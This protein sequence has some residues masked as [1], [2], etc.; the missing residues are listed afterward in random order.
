MTT[1]PGAGNPSPA[2][3]RP[4]VLD[5]HVAQPRADAPGIAAA[6]GH[7]AVD[8]ALVIVAQVRKPGQDTGGCAARSSMKGVCDT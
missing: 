1:A 5:D 3:S 8:A 7:L 4:L 6:V 2:R